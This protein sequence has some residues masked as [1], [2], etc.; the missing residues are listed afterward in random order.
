M[1]RV[2]GSPGWSRSPFELN[3]WSSH[4]H[5]QGRE[6]QKGPALYLSGYLT[7]FR[8]TP[9][10][11]RKR[12]DTLILLLANGKR[13]ER[14]WKKRVCRWRRHCYLSLQVTAGSVA[15]FLTPYPRKNMNTCPPNRLLGFTRLMAL[16]LA[17]VGQSLFAIS[18]LE[19]G[20]LGGNF[21]QGYAINNSGQITGQSHLTGGVERRP[22]VYSGG[23]MTDLGTLGG[24]NTIGRGINDSGQVVGFSAVSGDNPTHAFFYTE[25]T[26]MTDLGTLGGDISQALDINNSGQVV[27][28]SSLTGSTPLHAFLYTESDGMTDL[29]TLGGAGS[30]ARGINDSGQIVGNSNIASGQFHAFSYTESDGMTDLGTLGGAISSAESINNSGQIVGS[31]STLGGET[32]AFMYTGGGMI[33]L[34]TLGGNRS[35]AW[36]I[37]GFG[38][39]VGFSFITGNVPSEAHGFLYK[40]GGMIDLNVLALGLL[41][42]G[43]TAGF[44]MLGAAYGINDLGQIVGNGNYYDGSTTSFRSYLLDTRVPDTGGALGLFTLALTGLIMVKRRRSRL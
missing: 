36:D 14:L 28:F 12:G 40:D 43:T 37:N 41:S 2:N 7:F 9:G 17:L 6:Y 1:V 20:T 26:G 23:S 39:A 34:G 19:L 5:D 13:L 30:F 22:F 42:D 33:D 32:H 3:A 16:A 35:S 4:G 8:E 31:S 11:I 38:Q 44:T 10:A 29:G 18:L 27:G 25:S 15:D 24:T 21:T